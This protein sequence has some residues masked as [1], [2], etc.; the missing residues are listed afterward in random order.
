MVRDDFITE[1]NKVESQAYRS[2][3]VSLRKYIR[4]SQG[5]HISLISVVPYAYSKNI[6]YLGIVETEGGI[7]IQIL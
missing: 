2:F 5:R 7:I 3:D 6:R 1:R 4:L